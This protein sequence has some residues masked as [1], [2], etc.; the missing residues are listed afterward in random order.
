MSENQTLFV[1]M[2]RFHPNLASAGKRE[3][4]SGWPHKPI[5]SQSDRPQHRRHEIPPLVGEACHLQRHA[6]RCLTLAA[7]DRQSGEAAVQD[8]VTD[9][10][11][12]RREAGEP[13]ADVEVGFGAPGDWQEIDGASPLR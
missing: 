1:A 4:L 9:M 5:S 6:D 2:N 12:V 10:R 3:D 7:G 11:L 13:D 8:Q